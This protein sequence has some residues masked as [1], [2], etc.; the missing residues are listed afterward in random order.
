MEDAPL[1]TRKRELRD[2]VDRSAPERDRWVRRYRYSHAEDIR[3]LRFLVPPGLRVLDIGC[4]SGEAL[5]ALEPAFG[6]GVDLSQ[7]MLRLARSRHPGLTF[8]EGDVESDGFIATLPGPFDVIIISGT[9]G[10][11][12]DCEAAFR[13]LHRQCTADTRLVISYWSTLWQPAFAAAEFLR[14]KSRSL[15]LNWLTTRDICEILALADFEPIKREWKQLIP[16]RVL[17]LGPLVNRYVATLPL[18]RQL[19]LRNY[20]VARSL[21]HAPRPRPS[22]TV[23]VPCRNERGNVESAVTRMPRFA[24]DLEIIFVEGHSQDGTLEEIRRVIAKYP[25]RDIK[26]LVQEGRGKGDAVR[27]GFDQAR[28]DLLMILDADLTMPPEALAKFHD[29]WVSGKG[30]FVNGSRLVYPL[31][32]DAMRFLNFVANKTFSLLFTWLLNQRFTDTL[33]GTKVLS[34]A[35]Y[36]AIAANRAYFGDFDPFGDFDLIFGA[37]KQ[38]LKTVEIPI[39][40]V[41]RAYGETQISRFR[42]GWLLARMVVFAFWKLKAY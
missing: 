18:I 19:C 10:S 2:F 6:V 25:E 40:Y 26:C 1:S 24:D 17:G 23:V 21:R 42:H 9:I 4:G 16:A 12:D 30:E 35:H 22:V 39:R 11:L 13:A 5:A 7:E 41:A 14:L 3:H 37:A 31:E 38:N 8:I 20:V 15:P 29:A 32:K 36:R 27:L 28:G 34:R 33:C